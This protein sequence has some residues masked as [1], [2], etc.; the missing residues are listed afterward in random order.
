MLLGFLISYMVV[1][2][3]ILF[4]AHKQSP[5][6]PTVGTTILV[7]LFG[8]PLFLLA[9]ILVLKGGGKGE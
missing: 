1:N 5:V 6:P 3:G 2:A 9:G 4:L 7:S 8:L